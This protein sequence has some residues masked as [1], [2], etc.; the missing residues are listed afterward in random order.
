MYT[1]EYLTNVPTIDLG[2]IILRGIEYED[3]E[4]MYTY[5]SDKR[6]TQY[7]SWHYDSIESCKKGIVEVHLSRPRRKLPLTYAIVLKETNDLIGTCDFHSIDWNKREGEIG[8]VLAYNYWNKGYMTMALKEVIEFGFRYLKLQKI[9]ISHWVENVGS[10]RVI[11]KAG[12]RFVE[13]KIHPK[14]NQRNRF[15]ELEEK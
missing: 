5:A 12:F 10:R 13:E 8:Y 6:V 14:T 7:L 2:E 3:Y 15:Y 4:A 1:L 9:V 11:E